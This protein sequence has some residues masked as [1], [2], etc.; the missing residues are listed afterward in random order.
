V[1]PVIHAAALALAVGAAAHIGAATQ[2]SRPLR[3]RLAASKN[4]LVI[5]LYDLISCPFCS[6][7]WLAAGATAVYR[8]WLLH[9]WYPADFIA[10]ALAIS[11]ASMLPVLWIRKALKA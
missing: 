4:R 1:I 2:I 7:V 8:P 11:A 3:M 5:W 9:I 10:T 6:S